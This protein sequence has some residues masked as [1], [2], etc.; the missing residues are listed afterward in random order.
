MA[1]LADAFVTNPLPHFAP[2]PSCLPPP[3]QLDLPIEQPTT[4]ELIINVKTARAL[5]M[6]L[7]S[8][9]L[10]RADRMIE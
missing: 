7:S 10:L 1:V 8:P 6:T 4:F 5:G 3:A 2:S 9:I